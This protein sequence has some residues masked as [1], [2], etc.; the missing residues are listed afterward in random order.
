VDA[1]GKVGIL[2]CPNRRWLTTQTLPLSPLDAEENSP[3]LVS[4]GFSYAVVWSGD[5]VSFPKAQPQPE[6]IHAS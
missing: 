2:L 1:P 4:L 6:E 5:G 3:G